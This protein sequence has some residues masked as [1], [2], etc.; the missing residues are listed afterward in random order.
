MILAAGMDGIERKLDLEPETTNDVWSLT[1]TQR[2]AL[3]VKPLPNSLEQALSYMEKSEFV[4]ETLGEHIF[5]YFLKN[6]RDEC[7][8]YNQQITQFE[9]D[10]LFNKL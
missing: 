7:E 3:G 4:A 10:Y 9:T 8:K 1:E 2:R 6:K 5:D